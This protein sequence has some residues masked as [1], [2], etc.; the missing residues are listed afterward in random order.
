MFIKTLYELKH[1]KTGPSPAITASLD[2]CQIF[3]KS[4]MR[5]IKI[6]SFRNDSGIQMIWAVLLTYWKE[7]V[8]L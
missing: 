8:K 6:Q 5:I 7:L 1:R 4:N 3:A 2:I